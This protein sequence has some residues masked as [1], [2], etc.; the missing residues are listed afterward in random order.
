MNMVFL[1]M[2][3]ILIFMPIVGALIIACVPHIH[4]AKKIALMT[5][6]FELVIAL[7]LVVSFDTSNASFQF[8][9]QYA[10]IPSLNAAFFLGV[11]GISLLFLPMTALLMF[12]T[13]I[14][15]WYSIQHLTRLH[16]ALL[17]LLESATMG[18]FSALD[19]LL[20]FLFWEATLPPIFFLIGLWGIG[21]KRSQAALKYTLFML[22]GGVPLLFAIILLAVNHANQLGELITEGLSFSFP[23]LVNTPM[24][25]H[26]QLIILFLFV[27]G[28]AVKTPLVPFHT[29]LP[30]IA[31]ESPTQLSAL[32]MGLKLGAFGL[33]RFALPFA[34][35]VAWHYAW[36]LALFGAITLIYGALI[37]LKQTNLR[38]L[39][40]YLSLSHV[41]FVTMGIASLTLQ[42]IQGAL[43]QLLNFTLI[44]SSLMF[45]AGFLQQRIGSTELVHLGGLAKVLPKL[46]VFF[47]LFS[48]A[49]IGMPLTSGFPA[50][51]LLIIGVFK[52]QFGLGVVGLLGAILGAAALFIFIQKAF[53]GEVR[54]SPNN[55]LEDLRSHELWVLCIPLVLVLFLGLWPQFFLNIS[56][57]SLVLWLNRLNDSPLTLSLT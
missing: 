31:M 29:W 1:P 13:I 8:I 32:L 51:I 54:H 15:S 20:F 3:S 42:S 26:L 36:L 43:F 34:P 38:Q 27:L 24:T 5:A 23:V 45:I 46:C 2:L 39:L 28:F 50:E 47:Y 4:W 30:T 57:G 55:Q 49:S 21:A 19:M 35:S 7:K 6:F 17:L 12:V 44:A 41:G 53:L 14:A 37:A 9:E 11:D 25:D 16:F 40:A 33:L 56:Q 48:F 52:H 10:W 22:C 18:V